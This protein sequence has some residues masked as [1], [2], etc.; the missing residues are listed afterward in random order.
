MFHLKILLFLRL[1]DCSLGEL[2]WDKVYKA[3]MVCCKLY[4]NMWKVLHGDVWAV[5][6]S[7]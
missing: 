7:E 3:S 2:L 4:V 6:V 5:K 1:W